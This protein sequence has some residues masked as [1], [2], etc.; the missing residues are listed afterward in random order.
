MAMR[1]KVFWAEETSEGTMK[2]DCASFQEPRTS[3]EVGVAR[4]E[5]KIGDE[6]MEE[7]LHIKQSLVASVGA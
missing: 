3:K 6:C 1:E 2:V 7:K 5:R 4:G